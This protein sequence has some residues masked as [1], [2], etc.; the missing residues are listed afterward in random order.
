MSYQLS[1]LMPGDGALISIDMDDVLIWSM[2]A[3][4]RNGATTE[5]L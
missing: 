4:K 1:P 2:K 5:R 3:K